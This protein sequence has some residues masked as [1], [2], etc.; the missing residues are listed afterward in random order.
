[1]GFDLFSAEEHTSP[2]ITAVQALPGMDV[3]DFQ[4][5]LQR[6]HQILISSGLD[7]LFG[8]IFRVGHIGK[9]ASLDYVEALLAGVEAYLGQGPG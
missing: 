6:E 7:D 5:Y 9:A 3:S 8:K 1:M 4:R 2:L